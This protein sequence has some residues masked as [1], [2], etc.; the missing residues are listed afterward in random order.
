MDP[1]VAECYDPDLLRYIHAGVIILRNVRVYPPEPQPFEAVKDMVRTSYLRRHYRRL[2]SEVRQEI[3]D[4][5]DLEIYF[6][7][8]PAI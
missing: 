5:M 7:R 6:D 2:E 8:L 1:V 3:M 4:S